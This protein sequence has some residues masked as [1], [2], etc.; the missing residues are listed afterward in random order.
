MDKDR[1]SANQVPLSPLSFL[2]RATNFFADRTAVQHGNRRFSYRE[3]GDRV[4]RLANAL[5][6]SNVRPG[7][8]V[9]ILAPNIPAMLEA[10]FAVPMIGAHLNPINFRLPAETIAEF[11]RDARPK[12]VIVD[13]EFLDLARQ[14]TV[15]AGIEI[16]LICENSAGSP[17]TRPGGIVDY[18]AFIAGATGEP[19]CGY[20]SD[21]HQDI[22]HLYTSGTTGTPRAIRYTHRSCYLA[23]LNNALSFGLTPTTRF[24]WTWPMFHSNGLSF[25][26][27]VTAVGGTHICARSIDAKSIGDS[28]AKDGVT[29]FCAAPLVLNVMASDPAFNP[30]AD[31][32][33]VICITGGSPPPSSVLRPLERLG[34]DFIHQYGASECHGPVTMAIPGLE[35]AGTS[36]DDRR[37]KMARQGIPLPAIEDLIVAKVDTNVPVARDGMTVGEVLVRGNTVAAGYVND[38]STEAP[39]FAD[40]WYRTGDMAVWYG[41]GTIEITDRSKDMIISGGENISSIEIEDVLFRHPEVREAAVVAKPDPHMVQIPCAFV[42]RV[43]GSEI[44]ASDLEQHCREFLSESKIPR[45]FIF[46]TLPK[47]ETGKVRKNSLRDIILKLAD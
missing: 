25:I 36:A 16:P 32:R 34:I 9:S 15:L 43:A 28:I 38:D 27:S 29:H 2:R 19:I 24:L 46:R 17:G 13:C 44:E 31:S 40:G 26:W 33:S 14:A 30:Q 47:T 3:F 39:A 21:E 7:D 5:A 35:E 6:E 37:R 20:P 41:D 10:H 12:C 8:S 42:D 1:V 22:A 23:A 18:E 45:E 11:L 4:N